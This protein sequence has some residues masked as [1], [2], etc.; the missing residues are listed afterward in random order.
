MT[1]LEWLSAMSRVLP[2]VRTTGTSFS[3]GATSGGVIE[4]VEVEPPELA[5]A[6]EAGVVVPP[7]AEVPLRFWPD[8]AVC[9][10]FCTC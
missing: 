4:V 5:P 3:V 10:S 9:S 7:V 6:L 1:E 2:M 8:C